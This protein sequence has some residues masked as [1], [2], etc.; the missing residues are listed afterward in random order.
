MWV[1]RLT[2]Y[3]DT[4]EE[5]FM[6]A[7]EGYIIQVSRNYWVEGFD[8]E[9]I[10][11]ELRLHLW[12]K[13]KNYDPTKGTIETWGRK[14]LVN[15]VRDLYRRTDPLCNEHKQ[16]EEKDAPCDIDGNLEK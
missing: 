7:L 9:D 12:R 3:E 2:T 13:I 10:A 5:N 15:R 8:S 14:V 16:L 11:Q 6:N 4:P 1:H